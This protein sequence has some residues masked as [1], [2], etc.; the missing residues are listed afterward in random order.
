MGRVEKKLQSNGPLQ[1]LTA[2]PQRLTD[3]IRAKVVISRE[4]T[5]N[6]VSRGVFR[7][8]SLGSRLAPECL[9][10]LWLVF[11]LGFLGGCGKESSPDKKRGFVLHVH[12]PSS[13]SRTEAR[14]SGFAQ[15]VKSLE[16]V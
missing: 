5:W 6:S 7:A 3:F 13:V 1:Y 8:N 14:R 16:I 4:F 9:M 12:P 2:R 15:R 11:F 10:T